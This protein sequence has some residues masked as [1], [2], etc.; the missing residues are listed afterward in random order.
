M[1]FFKYKCYGCRIIQD[2]P[3]DLLP[4]NKND[5]LYCAD[6]SSDVKSSPR[7]VC[8]DY[9]P[10]KVKLDDESRNNIQNA[11]RPGPKKA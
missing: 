6:C 8:V 2:F 1:K 7:C 10:K 3:L 4:L 9:E 11:G 5:V